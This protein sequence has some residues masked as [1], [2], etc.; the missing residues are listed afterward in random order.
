[1]VSPSREWLATMNGLEGI[2]NADI[3]VL[4]ITPS[5]NARGTYHPGEAEYR[6]LST[7]A[8][9]SAETV[10]DLTQR[11]QMVY[12]GGEEITPESFTREA[13]K[14]NQI[15]YGVHL[16]PDRNIAHDFA[17]GLTKRKPREGGVVQEFVIRPN[18]ALDV[19]K[20]LYEEGTPQFK[21]LSKIATR[22][23]IKD[24][25]QFYS[26]TV[27]NFVR[28]K[29]EDTFLA[30][31][32]DR[33]LQHANP[34]TVKEV[35][36]ELGYDPLVAYTMLPTDAL[37]SPLMRRGT[38]AYVAL[39]EEALNPLT[40]REQMGLF[41]SG[42]SPAESAHA[43]RALEAASKAYNKAKQRY[44]KKRRGDKDVHQLAF[45][46]AKAA[47]TKALIESYV[48]SRGKRSHFLL[49][50]NFA[51]RILEG[52]V[53]QKIIDQVLRAIGQKSIAGIPVNKLLGIR[54][55]VANTKAILT[56]YKK[57]AKMRDKAAKELDKIK[58]RVM[59]EMRKLMPKGSTL[60]TA[61]EITAL[62]KV[63]K[64]AKT[65]DGIDQAVDEVTT[66][67]MAKITKMTQADILKALETKTFRSQ[68]QRKI[69]ASLF[70][71]QQEVMELIKNWIQ[72]DKFHLR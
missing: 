55:R 45:E 1:M 38:P 11:E 29:G 49:N 33:V 61:K 39:S 65:L 17:T 9:Q 2:E 14:G 63:I 72:D 16:T 30:I 25:V 21:V 13:G 42:M 23:N 67:M 20:G 31:N 66:M 12:H 44:S 32:P 18:K 68:G 53:P 62:F 47:A 51:K 35:L 46:A 58:E 40:Q 37:G 3:G 4:E 7:G 50:Q 5:E 8:I 69:S 27:G 59:V 26:P 64:Q 48:K 56:E 54:E 60:Y 15:P 57:D 28:K 24:I 10:Y 34:I 41:D 71:N 6:V 52:T 36:Q 19:R 43:Q 70:V 22:S